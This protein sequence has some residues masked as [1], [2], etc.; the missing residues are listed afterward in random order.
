M[1]E[2][3][4]R[5]LFERHQALYAGHV[6]PPTQSLMAFG[7]DCGDGWYAILAALSDVLM[8]RRREV[9]VQIEASQVKEK[10]GTLCFYTHFHDDYG[11]GAIRLARRMSGNVCEGCGAPASNSNFQG[12][13]ATCCRACAD[14][15]PHRA[16]KDARRPSHWTTSRI[17]TLYRTALVGPEAVD[18]GLPVGWHALVAETIDA[19][20][21]MQW[22][23]PIERPTH[24][25][26]PPVRIAF[27]AEREGRLVVE[28]EGLLNRPASKGWPDTSMDQVAR[29]I[30][31]CSAALSAWCDRTTGAFLVP[32]LYRAAQGGIRAS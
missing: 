14:A 1:D 15:H 26:T 31:D 6:L 11:D 28:L 16:V 27:V 21:F 18:E 22:D 8:K 17:R 12:W 20:V 7:F 4:E 24:R 10:F 3:L 25:W 23:D 9:G 13:Y 2:R 19:L 32:S 30:V 29:G 5:L